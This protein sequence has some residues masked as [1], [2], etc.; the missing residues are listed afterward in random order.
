MVCL[1]HPLVYVFLYI[2]T[3]YKACSKTFGIYFE[4]VTLYCFVFL[5]HFNSEENTST[6]VL[7]LIKEE[8]VSDFKDDSETEVHTEGTSLV[9]S[10]VSIQVEK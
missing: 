9:V 7:P 2:H 10:D 8:A 4:L 3:S 6:D 5:Q 1:K